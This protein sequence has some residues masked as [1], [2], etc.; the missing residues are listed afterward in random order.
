M[1][2]IS[3]IFMMSVTIDN[4]NAFAAKAEKTMFYAI[5]KAMPISIAFDDLMVYREY[6]NSPLMFYIFF[7]KEVWPLKN[8]SW[9]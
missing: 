4:I 1:D 6:F 2:K 3:S 8:L 7:N 9:R 5:K